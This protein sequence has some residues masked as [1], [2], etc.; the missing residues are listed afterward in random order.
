M[1][2]QERAYQKLLNKWAREFNSEN[3]T[4][5]KLEAILDLNGYEIIVSTKT[6]EGNLYFSQALKK[7]VIDYSLFSRE[8]IEE[9]PVKEFLISLKEQILTPTKG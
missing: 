7:R 1:K 6:K 2:L 5:F 9:T 4:K 3:D 8:I